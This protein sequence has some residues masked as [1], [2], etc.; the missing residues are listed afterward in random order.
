MYDRKTCLFPTAKFGHSRLNSVYLGTILNNM[1]VLSHSVSD[2]QK[3][4]SV[5]QDRDV[6]RMLTAR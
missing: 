3:N 1:G 5:I 6:H 2:E 4:R